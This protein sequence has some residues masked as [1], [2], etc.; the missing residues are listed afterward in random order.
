MKQNK[1]KRTGSS[2]PK[3]RSEADQNISISETDL[4]RIEFH[5]NAFALMPEP[6]DKKPGIAF[7]VANAKSRLKQ[8]FC[9]CTVSKKRTCPHIVKLMHAYKMLNKG[10]SEKGI[11][12]DFTSTV[13]HKLGSIMGENA[14][15]KPSITRSP[16]GF[17]SMSARISTTASMRSPTETCCRTSARRTRFGSTT[18]CSTWPRLRR[19]SSTDCTPILVTCSPTRQQISL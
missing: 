9:S 13:W 5:R 11:E 8:R 16:I 15:E 2:V 6:T 3:D 1:K 14:S 4:N 19:V 17:P 7:F 18:R 12:A 10:P